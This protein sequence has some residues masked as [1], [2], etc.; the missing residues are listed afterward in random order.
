MMLKIQNPKMTIYTDGACKFNPGPG[1]WGAILIYKD[2]EKTISGS[3]PHT[4][5]NRMELTAVI[6]ALKLL[7][8]T[9]KIN[10]Y[11]DS[12][13]VRQ[14]INIW[15]PKWQMKNWKTASGD[16]VKNQDLWEALNLEVERHDIDWHWVKAHNG[17]PLNERV[18]RLARQ[19]IKCVK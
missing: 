17:D 7:K 18:D 1:G 3:D 4:T 15:L 9:C 19:A 2:H 10:L 16:Q 13:Y 12:Q 5:N 8:Q 6:N 14:G 11:T